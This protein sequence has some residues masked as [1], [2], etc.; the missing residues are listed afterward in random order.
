VRTFLVSVVIGPLMLIGLHAAAGQ[1]LPP[2]RPVQLAASSDATADRDTYV[3]KAQDDLGDWQQ[4]LHEF[5]EK[6]KIEGQ[7]VSTAAENDLNK[8]WAKT[9]TEAGKLQSTSAEDW[10]SAKLSYEKALR[11]LRDDWRKID[12]EDK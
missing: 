12:G 3:R 9:K 5:G 2:D 10:G 8:A 1:S 11:E 7:K 6:A 4:K